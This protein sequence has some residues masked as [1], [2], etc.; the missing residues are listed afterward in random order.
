MQNPKSIF[1]GCPITKKFIINALLF[2][3][4]WFQK[5]QKYN[6]ITDFSL[7]TPLNNEKNRGKILK[8]LSFLSLFSIFPQFSL[9]RGVNNLKSQEN[10]RNT[11]QSVL[12]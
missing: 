6:Q 9:F 5:E 11:E 3:P 7:F 8:T 10:S 12:F 2:N 4:K 1:T